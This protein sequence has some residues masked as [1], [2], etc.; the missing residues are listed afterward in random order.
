M[1]NIISSDAE[2][3]WVNHKIWNMYRLIGI[4]SHVHEPAWFIDRMTHNALDHLIFVKRVIGTTC[5]SVR[6]H[7]L[8]FDCSGQNST[9][10][11]LRRCF[12]GKSSSEVWCTCDEMFAWISGSWIR[13]WSGSLLNSW[14]RWPEPQ[15]SPGGSS[16]RLRNDKSGKYERQRTV[17][18]IREIWEQSQSAYVWCSSSASW[19]SPSHGS[20]RLVS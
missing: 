4:Y 10:C 6:Q 15:D 13:R 1:K 7:F 19:I 3:T 14:T 5:I 12:H 17:T 8:L 20:L 18:S 2:T 11:A 16:Q 9:D